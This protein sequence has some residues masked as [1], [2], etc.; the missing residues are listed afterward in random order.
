MT[1]SSEALR[2]SPVMR[3]PSHHKVPVIQMS[4]GP[5]HLPV[6]GQPNTPEACL[7]SILFAK[8]GEPSISVFKVYL[9]C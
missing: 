9:V 3:K 5:S 4:Q 1:T 8:G 2:G 7:A 6:T